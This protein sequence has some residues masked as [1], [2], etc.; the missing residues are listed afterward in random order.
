MCLTLKMQNAQEV[1]LVLSSSMVDQLVLC[2]V[3]R[4]QALYIG[5]MR[6]D[7]GL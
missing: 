1:M 7:I 5:Y 6:L 3:K 2:T 4:S